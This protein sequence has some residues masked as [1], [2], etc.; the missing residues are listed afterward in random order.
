MG[1]SPII[2]LIA[3]KAAVMSIERNEAKQKASQSRS[4]RTTAEK[5][6]APSTSV[7][8]SPTIQSAPRK[9]FPDLT[10][11]TVSSSFSVMECRRAGNF[12]TTSLQKR[13]RNEKSDDQKSL[14]V[15][16]RVTIGEKKGKGTNRTKEITSTADEFPES[17]MN[18]MRT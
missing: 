9:T 4:S 18:S 10:S 7:Q 11:P 16:R 3:R 17:P 1:T 6:H 8:Y 2:F 12:S 14:G 13:W 5:V 15:R